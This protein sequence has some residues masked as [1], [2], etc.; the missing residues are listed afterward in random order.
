M[1]L[2]T[3]LDQRVE[4]GAANCK[5]LECQIKIRKILLFFHSRVWPEQLCGTERCTELGQ[6]KGSGI[7]DNPGVRVWA[8]W[9]VQL[10]WCCV[11]A[12]GVVLCE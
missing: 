6:R 8:H 4:S 10:A 7:G 9:W 1:E 2:L 11:S 3:V 12:V 5:K